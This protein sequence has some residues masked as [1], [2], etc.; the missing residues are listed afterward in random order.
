[1]GTLI[2]PYSYGGIV[3]GERFVG[4]HDERARLLQR[5]VHSAE[6]DSAALVGPPRTGKSSLAWE[7]LMTSTARHDAPQVIPVWITL[8]DRTGLTDLIRTILE[9]VY[10]DL[11]KVGGLRDSRLRDPLDAAMRQALDP[12]REWDEFYMDAKKT[13]RLVRRHGWRV[14]VVLDEFDS[15]RKIFDDPKYAFDVLRAL[16]NEQDVRVIWVTTSRRELQ[17]I[18]DQAG[19]VGSNLPHLFEEIP[20]RCFEDDELAEL[21]GRAVDSGVKINVVDVLTALRELTGGHPWLSSQALSEACFMIARTGQ[22]DWALITQKM[23]HP[24]TNY[25]DDLCK[26]LSE[27]G[28]LDLLLEI[29][30]GPQ[31]KAKVRDLLQLANTGI[32]VPFD[33]GY[34]AFSAHFSDYLRLQARTTDTSELWSDATDSL[35]DHVDT[36]F[37][38]L[39]DDPW[40]AAVEREKPSSAPVLAHLRQAREQEARSFGPLASAD[41]LDFA[42]PSELWFFIELYWE[43]FQPVLGPADPNAWRPKFAVLNK[44]RQPLATSPTGAVSAR[45]RQNAR[46]YCTEILEKLN[47]SSAR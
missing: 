43:L 20:V 21:V 4:R 34:R 42:T 11:S 41:L 9:L 28:R 32:L 23:F 1:M 8:A 39:F 38:T 36:T 37:R 26:L 45:M 40:D 35:R 46:D 47:K 24:F 5:V 25:Y 33:S 31:L 22:V 2:N 30:F 12:G 19:N 16:T 3:F 44:V 15:A 14:I 6:G 18:V 13:L 27:D 29:L 17:Q 7:T 10:D